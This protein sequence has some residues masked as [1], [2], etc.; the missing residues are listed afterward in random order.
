M[1]MLIATP[2]RNIKEYCLREYLGMLSSLKISDDIQADYLIVD[3]S[4]NNS[5]VEKIK[6]MCNGFKAE[7][8]NI[9]FGKEVNTRKRLCDCY[10]YIRRVALE[11][12]YD[13]LFIIEQDVIPPNDITE[14]LLSVNKDVVCAYYCRDTIYAKDVPMFWVD[15]IVGCINVHGNLKEHLMG[16]IDKNSIPKQ[17]FRVRGS[18]LGC[19]MIKR[20]VLRNVKFMY[21][22]DWTN[23]P[24]YFFSEWCEAMGYE[25]VVVPT[26][27]KHIYEQWSKEV[28]Y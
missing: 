1:K 20:E 6:S 16:F 2:T 21:D 3:N 15:V 14:R 28:V 22:E 5:Y 11:R 18:G 24:D 10:N 19:V 8:V 7:V 9:Q 17:P 23:H 25:M 4:D 13:Y 12:G 26:E 27:C